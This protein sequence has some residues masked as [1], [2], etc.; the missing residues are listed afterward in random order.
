MRGKFP[1]T[2][3][4]APVAAALICAANCGEAPTGM[5]PV[6]WV[7]VAVAP[8]GWALVGFAAQPGGV[9]FVGLDYAEEPARPAIFKYDGHEFA[10]V[11][12]PPYEADEAWL[13]AIAF[14]GDKGWA[15]GGKRSE[16]PPPPF[17]PLMFYYDGENWR[18]VA[19]PNKECGSLNA[20]SP[21]NERDCWLLGEVDSFGGGHLIKYE[22]GRFEVYEELGFKKAMAVARDTGTIYTPAGSHKRPALAISADR[23]ASWVIESPAVPTLGYKFENWLP[24]CAAGDDLY[25]ILKCEGVIWGIVRRSGPPGTGEYELEFLEVNDP[26]FA[27]INDVAIGPGRVAAVG[28]SASAFDYGRGWRREQLPYEIVLRQ[29]APAAGGNGFW[30]FGYNE[31]IMGRTELLYHP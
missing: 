30:A 18:E 12:V 14:A 27:K 15:V 7:P 19:V 9:Y 22:D 13:Q 10:E 31:N 2:F 3:I 29:V 23:G 8:A 21:I 28:L 26:E 24:A 11:F 25:L 16:N 20:V 17:L 4:L 1:K 6:A 5:D